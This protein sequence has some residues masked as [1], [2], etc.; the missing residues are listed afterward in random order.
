MLSAAAPERPAT[1]PRA[2]GRLLQ[3]GSGGF[4]AQNFLKTASAFGGV[5]RTGR[6]RGHVQGIEDTK[7]VDQLVLQIHFWAVVRKQEGRGPAIL[8]KLD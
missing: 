5:S 4:I 2:V 6:D 7:A 3:I 1:L 8:H